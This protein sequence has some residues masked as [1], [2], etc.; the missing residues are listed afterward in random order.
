MK[1]LITFVLGFL[2]IISFAQTKKVLPIIDMH[3][4]A[5]P[6]DFEGPPPVGMCSPFEH[7]HV[8]DAKEIIGK[9]K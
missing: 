6:A 4:H 9:P 5:L 7:W 2:T 3:M 1:Y 8:R